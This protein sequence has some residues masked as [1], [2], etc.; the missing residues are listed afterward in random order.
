[1]KQITVWG[2]CL[3]LVTACAA[4]KPKVE[5]ETPSAHAHHHEMHQEAT[6]EKGQTLIFGAQPKRK[7]SPLLLK[8]AIGKA[9]FG[10]ALKLTGEVGSVCQKAG[11]W[12]ILRDGET[13][14][15]ITFKDY[16]FFVPKNIGGKKIKSDLLRDEFSCF[17]DFGDSMATDIATLEI[18]LSADLSR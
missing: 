16:S 8:E 12:M 3:L 9:N 18:E 17:Q 14:A 2:T 10:K 15:R 11:C 7:E 4:Q 5:T 6:I 1:M 13:T